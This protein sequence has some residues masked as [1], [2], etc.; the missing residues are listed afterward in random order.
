MTDQVMQQQAGP[1]GNGNV[2]ALGIL[3]IFF[4]AMFVLGGLLLAII[5]GAG[6]ALA[7]KWLENVGGDAWGSAQWGTLGAVMFV[8]MG[9]IIMALGVPSIISGVGLMRYQSWGRIMTL[10]LASLAG[11]SALSALVDLDIG[12]AL[13]PGGF[14]AYAWIILTRPHIVALFGR[15][16]MQQQTVVIQAP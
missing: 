7:G 16:P 3:Q 9:L 1:Q 2:L 13:I 8:V 6:S 10:V 12:G 4:G 11:L 5:G 14:C 15:G